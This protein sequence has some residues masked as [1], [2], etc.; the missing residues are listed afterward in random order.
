M[1]SQL[2]PSTNITPLDDN[3]KDKGISMTL[4]SGPGLW[5]L[6]GGITSKDMAKLKRNPFYVYALFL[7][8][9][10]SWFFW[11]KGTLTWESR[12]DRLGHVSC[13]LEQSGLIALQ[14]KIS[15]RG[16]VQGLS[17]MSMIMITLSYTIREIETFGLARVPWVTINGMAIEL[18]QVVSCM[19]AYAG[20]WSIFKKYRSS[21][22]SDLDVLK[23]KYL[24]PCCVLLG[25]V[26]Q[27]QFRQGWKYS[28]SWAVSF[29]IDVLALLPQVV[30]MQRSGG[31]VE[32]PIAHYV[33]ATA[34]SRT[35]DLM[36]W[37]Y[38]SNIGP[39]GWWRGYNVSGTIIIV[40][41]IICLLL[42]A[43]FMYYYVKARIHG[44]NMTE[45]VE[46]AEQ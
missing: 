42:L 29:Y 4:G 39:Q 41:H 25:L 15:L 14:W 27:P 11:A 2:A 37:C 23:V 3:A 28:L 6:R 46:I 31:K 1:Q 17:G 30:M 43:D 38:R 16:H 7:M 33:A 13:I 5:N 24:I 18:L 19:L 12:E 44:R 35:S 40:F 20:L 9:F 45:D 8:L 21:Y 26:L 22:Q 32:A 34:F 36:F 10:Y